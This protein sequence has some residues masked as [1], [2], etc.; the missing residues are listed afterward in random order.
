MH[1][2]LIR[3]V[4]SIVFLALLLVL[5]ASAQSSRPSGSS[6]TSSTRSGA[7]NNS[8]AA[9]DSSKIVPRGLTTWAVDERFGS[10]TPTTPD[11]MPHLFQ[12]TNFNDGV[13]GTYS[14]TGN[15]ASPRVSRIY[16]GQHDY[17]MGS[18]FIFALPYSM[19]LQSV[20]DLVFTNT[21]SPIT[22]ITW[23]SQGNKTNGDDR[24]RVNFAT[25]INKRAGLGAKVDYL[26]G[27]GYYSHQNT[28]SIASKIYGSY[29]ADRYSLHAAYILDRTKNAENGGLTDDTYI[30][31]PE[32][33]STK[34]TP[35]DM[36]VRL[37]QAYNNLKINTLF[38]THRYNLG[39]YE[40]V[41]SA[42]HRLILTD[43]LRNDSAT[44]AG[45][46]Q[47]TPVAAIVHTAKV[48]HN[49]RRYFDYSRNRSF[50]LDDFFLDNDTILDR[51]RYTSVENTFALEMTEG[52]RRWV[53]TGMR[54]FAKHQYARFTLPDADL[55][56]VA[57]T[58]NY[59][60]L[61]GQLMREQG[62]LF[63]YNV[64]GE[65][66]TT[67][68]DWG[69]FNVEGN[70]DLKIPI[71]QDSVAV[72]VDGFVRNELPSYYYRHFHSDGAWWDND[73]LSKVFRSRLEGTFR[74][75]NTRLRLGFETI[76]NHTFFQEHQSWADVGNPDGT[77]RSQVHYGVDVQQADKN[78]Q[79]LSAALGQ[80]LRFGPL[81]WENELTVQHSSNNQVLPLPVFNAWS[82]LYFDFSIAHVLHTNLGADL[83]YFTRYNAPTYVPFIGMYAVQDAE[84]ATPIGNYP[85]V[86]VYANFHLK[87]CRFYVMYSHVSQYAGPYFLTPHCPTNQR[88]FRIGISWN[89]FN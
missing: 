24:L 4:V 12:F 2:R 1:N 71:L 21:K 20:S 66:R 18:Q 62:H 68:E 83:R 75:R 72:R 22:N 29:R 23:M 42:G 50:Y 57:N 87:T 55:Q 70:I 82:N 67:G 3:R 9:V 26:Y 88:S 16:N 31:H 61:G 77:D 27:R 47:F 37:N 51:T 80:T 15:L 35:A 48:D 10:V 46:R 74:W 5:H 85:W 81:V 76:Q 58:F 65:I 56:S 59:I 40:L 13:L 8:G 11:T 64:L 7:G 84:H 52:F 86:N 53:K 44:L 54:L 39:F 6:R 41:D 69:E 45:P 38:L 28:S 43:S 17:M 25:N 14:H 78:V 32:Y 73:D 49:L 89:F 33:F 63:H 36:P 60:T 30:T 19:A 34:Y 79:V